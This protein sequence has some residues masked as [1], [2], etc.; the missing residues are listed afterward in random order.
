MGEPPQCAEGLDRAGVQ[1]VA[2][3]EQD[4]DVADQPV[5]DREGRQSDDDDGAEPVSNVAASLRG[6]GAGHRASSGVSRAAVFARLVPS[7]TIRSL[8]RSS[9]AA[10]VT[11]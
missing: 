3:P 10:L 4:G 6:V 7:A 1:R 11:A 2:V 5:P 8:S 9:S